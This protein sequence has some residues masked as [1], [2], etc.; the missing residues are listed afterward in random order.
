[1]IPWYKHLVKWRKCNEKIKQAHQDT[2]N[3]QEEKNGTMGRQPRYYHISDGL[4]FGLGGFSPV[5]GN[6]EMF[7]PPPFSLIHSHTYTSCTSCDFPPLVDKPLPQAAPLRPQ[8]L[9][10]SSQTVPDYAGTVL[11]LRQITT[12]PT[13]NSSSPIIIKPHSETVG[14]IEAGIWAI[15]SGY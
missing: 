10:T 9:P 8:H 12:A 1:M 15:N 3:Q 11:N 7:R 5:T 13:V 4:F 14:T 6:W 2:E